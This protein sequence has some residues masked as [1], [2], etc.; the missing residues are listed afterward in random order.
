M[1]AKC[2]YDDEYIAS[3]R[4]NVEEQLDLWKKL[5][6]KSQGSEADA[7]EP[8]FMSDLVLVMDSF[9]AHRTR[10]A[11]GK[12]GN[13]INE[14]TMIRDSLHEHGGVFTGNKMIRYKAEDSVL[15]LSEGDRIDL[16]A[17]GL[18]KLVPAYFDEMLAR[19]T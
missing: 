4:R 16:T 12:D 14:V 8:R 15:G 3:C 5:A 7:L 11:E 13:P 2:N 6:N 10:G 17:A 1:L 9:F 18:S 19:F